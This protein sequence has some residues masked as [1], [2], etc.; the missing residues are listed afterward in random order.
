MNVLSLNPI[1]LVAI[2][3]LIAYLVFFT[4]S[5]IK[6]YYI[7]RPRKDV[8]N[9]PADTVFR[10]VHKDNATVLLEYVNSKKTRRLFSAYAVDTKG[11]KPGDLVRKANKAERYSSQLENTGYGLLIPVDSE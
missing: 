4:W 9:L 7:G 5:S 8:K 1:L 2:F 6:S 3:L 10:L 11:C